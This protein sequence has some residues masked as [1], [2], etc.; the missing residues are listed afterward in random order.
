MVDMEG[1]VRGGDRMDKTNKAEK[2]K[3]ISEAS[4]G[5]APRHRPDSKAR[6]G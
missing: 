6:T 2:D 4:W 5:E 1:V 3:E